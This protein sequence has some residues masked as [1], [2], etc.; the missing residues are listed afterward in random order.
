LAFI[1]HTVVRKEQFDRKTT[2]WDPATGVT[3]EKVIDKSQFL[4]SLSQLSQK[5]PRYDISRTFAG[6]EA[7]LKAGIDKLGISGPTTVYSNLNYED[8]LKHEIKNRDGNLVSCKYGDTYAVDT[9]RFTG[10]S[11]KDKWFVKNQGTESESHIDWGNVNKPTTPEVYHE[12]YEKAVKYFNSLDQCYVFD[13]FV[14]ANPRSQKKVRF[15]TELA[16]QHHF[17]T[18]MFIRPIS[19][20]E[21]EHFEPDFTIINACGA[22]NE[23]W[24]RHGLNSEVAAAFNIEEKSA[25]ILGTYY[26]GEMKK[27]IFSLMN[28]WLPMEGSLSMHCSSNVG[29]DGNAAIF[30]GLSGT[31]TYSFRAKNVY[32]IL[33]ARGQI[34]VFRMVTS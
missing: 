29:K 32:Y 3:E 20:E 2:L 12:L 13:G 31:G 23:D 21:I 24:E 19:R 15:I 10:R 18:N 9:G 16:W 8:I 34:T 7:C 33:Y 6:P 5:P 14:G 17:V 30:F 22:V 28:Y 1:P 25:V 11:P 27:G 4:K 26:G